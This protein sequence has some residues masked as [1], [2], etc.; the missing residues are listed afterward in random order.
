MH[1]VFWLLVE[2]LI[3]VSLSFAVT[4][5]IARHLLPETFGRMSFLMALVSLVA[6]FMALGLNSLVSREV[7]QRPHDSDLIVGSALALR[8]G[9]GFLVAVLSSALAYVL[10]PPREGEM[11]AILLFASVANAALVFDFW[12]QAHVANRYGAL[13]RLCVL[14][15]FSALR[16][17]AVGAGADLSVFI[18]LLAAELVV[19]GVAYAAVYGRIGADLR[20]LRVTTRE[21][22][23]LLGDS[24]WLFFSGIAA[25][26]YLK[27]DQVMLGLLV[28]DHAV[29][30][31]AVAAKFSEVWYFLPAALVTSYF[32][33]LINKRLN[34]PSGYDLDLQK[35][36][37]ALFIFALAVA[38]LV[39]ATA[40]SLIPLFF[41]ESYIEAVPV[42]LVHI[43]AAILVFMRALLSKWLI[44][45]NLLRM[46]L[47]SQTL[48]A[49]AN[50]FLNY[51]LIPPYG[52]VGAAY[53]TI[54][55]YFLAGYLVLF[56]NRQLLPMALVV[57]RSFLLPFRVLR[58]GFNL[59]KVPTTKS[60][61]G[62]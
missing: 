25:V 38:V 33:Q 8:F 54:L 52:P 5:A 62:D 4:L 51:Y 61:G 20:H 13:L 6:P 50:V 14:L 24:G 42:L 46:S 56:C 44:T 47:L 11:I 40:D 15:L 26:I 29:G 9:A 58:R 59:Y 41:G 37:D 10:L 18:Y 21:C 34:D 27:V 53:A 45:E 48:G 60:D 43:W 36:N 31:Y 30:V 22:R 23:V 17:A 57:N 1:S 55:S 49:L 16:L 19:S 2:K 3:V 35:L 28:D 39:T 32:P 7:L 12:L